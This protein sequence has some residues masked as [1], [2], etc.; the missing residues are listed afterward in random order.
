MCGLKISHFSGWCVRKLA[1]LILFLEAARSG[2][3]PARVLPPPPKLNGRV[4][5]P[6]LPF[7]LVAAT[8]APCFVGRRSMLGL[9]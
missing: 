9:P 6:S 3:L 7:P 1:K 4:S 5:R 8:L 2:R